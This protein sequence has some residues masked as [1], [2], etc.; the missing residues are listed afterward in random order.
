MRKGLDDFAGWLRAIRPIDVGRKNYLFS[1]NDSGAEDN[2]IYY[3]LLGTCIEAG[4]DPYE[5]LTD[6]LKKTP[7]LQ[8][9]INWG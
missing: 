8:E 3:S 1:G 6:I 4:A 5:W 2:C 9:P 7:N